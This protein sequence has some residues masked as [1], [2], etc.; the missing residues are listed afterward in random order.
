MFG[1][2]GWPEM[3]VVLIIAL[4]LFGN[5][6]PEVMRNLGKSVNEFKRGMNDLGEEVA[7]EPPAQSSPTPASPPAPEEAKQA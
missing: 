5:R 2:V 7:K 6:L 1:S 4:L 3:L